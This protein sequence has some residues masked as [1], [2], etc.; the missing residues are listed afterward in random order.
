MNNIS[1]SNFKDSS[2]IISIESGI[3]NINNITFSNCIA[4]TLIKLNNN[5]QLKLTIN[6]IYLL[7][8]SYFTLFKLLGNIDYFNISNIYTSKFSTIQCDINQLISMPSNELLKPS[9]IFISN[10]SFECF[11]ASIFNNASVEFN[12]VEIRTTFRDSF[13]HSVND[14]EIRFKSS[15]FKVSNIDA[16]NDMGY[17]IFLNTSS[18]SFDNC[19][20]KDSSSSFLFS[21]NS[22]SIIIRNSNFSKFMSN[23]QEFLILV[24]YKNL[25]ISNSEFVDYSG[26]TFLY[27][28]SG[29][30]SLISSVKFTGFFVV[31][32]FEYTL[33]SIYSD[34]EIEGLI[35]SNCIGG[36]ESFFL[37]SFGNLVMS[38][39]IFTNNHGSGISSYL[40]INERVE[41][42]SFKSNN[43][44]LSNNQFINNAFS[45]IVFF[46]ESNVI[47][48]DTT[49]LNNVGS[50]IYGETGSK[51]IIDGL[52]I[53]NN[54]SP[55]NFLLA[56]ENA[57][58]VELNNIILENNY[59]TTPIICITGNVSDANLILN[60]FKFIGNK[61]IVFYGENQSFKKYFYFY[62]DTSVAQIMTANIKIT[63]NNVFITNNIFSSQMFNFITD[64]LNIT[65]GSFSN[66]QFI[67]LSGFKLIY[68]TASGSDRLV[69]FQNTIVSNNYD[70][71]DISE[72]SLI[73]LNNCY[74]LEIDFSEFSNNYFP[75]SIGSVFGVRIRGIF[76]KVG[77]TYN[78]IIQNS[79]FFNNSALYGGVFSLSLQIFVDGRKLTSDIRSNNFTD[80]YASYNGGVFYFPFEQF[81]TDFI[82]QKNNFNNNLL[83]FGPNNFGGAPSS[84]KPDFFEANGI[85]LLLIQFLILDQSNNVMIGIGGLFTASVSKGDP[86]TNIDPVVEY[87]NINIVSGQGSFYYSFNSAFGSYYSI[88]LLNFT[89][90]NSITIK[91]TGCG[92]FRYPTRNTSSTFTNC[93]YCPMG[94]VYSDLFYNS[95]NP[96]RCIKCDP[97][98]MVCQNSNVY[99]LD[100]Y[101]MVSPSKIYSCS[102]DMCYKKNTCQS[103]SSDIT[104]KIIYSLIQHYKRYI[105]KDSKY[106]SFYKINSIEKDIKR[107]LIKNQTSNLINQTKSQWILFQILYIPIMFNIASVIIYKEQFK[108]SKQID[109]LALDFS[110]EYLG[111]VLHKILFTLSIFIFI[112]VS[113]VLIIIALNSSSFIYSRIKYKNN[114]IGRI[115][116]ESNLIVQKTLSKLNYKRK[117][118]W[119]DLI[120]IIRSNIFIILS[121]ITLF[122]HH[123]Y[124]NI[125]L[126]IQTIY[127][128][129]FF[130]IHPIKT[131]K[132]LS[133]ESR[134]IN[135]INL[136]Q[137]LLYTIAQSALFKSIKPQHKV[138]RSIDNF[139]NDH[140]DFSIKTMY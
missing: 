75:N 14:G 35:V 28:N 77:Y 36:E 42:F 130:I 56:L 40:L 129:L 13:Y 24:G 117:Y 6:S 54:T 103:S 2:S 34:F 105:E 88:Q 11:G 53:K 137:I 49:Y 32:R 3:H 111:P 114:K 104:L 135:Q 52:A 139:L 16:S 92:T 120:I 86:D 69:K 81:N 121:L 136:F 65:G 128:T 133:S 27:S 118:R 94:S 140:P 72:T 107:I 90:L 100:N 101:Y 41:M 122:G 18:I 70:E 78:I 74:K 4:S 63:M 131:T 38:N 50:F 127:S 25:E 113:I 30:S 96:G 132:S 58:N 9:N 45:P 29:N 62:P 1:I 84:I 134:I 89:D 26:Q 7:Q 109:L 73:I 102:L 126:W 55:I 83:L 17:F 67:H 64:K 125:V 124:M 138:M 108:I 21:L 106:K 97:N 39:S 91:T 37:F 59:F 60:N 99:T 80:N 93:D 71:T 31:N 47:I 116:I 112:I 44:Q 85:E 15:F 61:V 76:G 79:K 95:S 20:L 22:Q 51:L 57:A 98:E 87:I 115:W 8:N 123:Y 82:L 5:N 48:Q 110:V 33:N 68:L 19:T 10:T 12:N 66:N 23:I 43:V 46:S 119:W